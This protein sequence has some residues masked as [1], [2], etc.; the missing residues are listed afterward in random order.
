MSAPS[1]RSAAAQQ[2]FETQARELGLDPEDPWIGGYVDYEWEHLRVLLD[3]YGVEPAGL[4]VLEFGCNVGASAIVLAALGAEVTAVDV[5][6]EMVA[7]AQSNADRY[8]IEGVEFIHVR[9]TRQLPLPSAAFDLI[10]CNSV[11]EY[12]Q[13]EQLPAVQRQLDRCLKVG[14]RILVTGTSSRLWPR[15][16]HSKRWLVNYLPSAVDRLLL[17]ERLQRGI[18]PWAVRSGFGPH[19]LNLDAADGGRAFTESRARFHTPAP[20]LFGLTGVARL[21]GVGPGMLAQNISCLLKKQA[22]S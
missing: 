3:C 19:Y 4:R 20:L 5:S 2:R 18:T 7:L 13:P 21:L 14:G 11:L 17:G 6:A 8:G 15:E 12:V 10:N 16:V 1:I 22:P 9:D